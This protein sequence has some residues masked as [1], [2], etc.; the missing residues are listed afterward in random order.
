[1]LLGCHVPKNFKL[2]LKAADVHNNVFDPLYQLF[3]HTSADAFLFS[4]YIY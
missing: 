3:N 1:M 4:L 2:L